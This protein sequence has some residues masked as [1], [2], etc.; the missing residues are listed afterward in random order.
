[1][2]ALLELFLTFF[3]L[4]LFT[5]GGGYAM[6]PQL[7]ETV[8]EKKK[9]LTED[10]VLNMI[11]ISESTPGPIAINMATFVGH[12]QKGFWGSLMA[13]LGV[14]LPSV[15]IIFII[16]LFF[17][18]FVS[19]KY[20]SYAFVGIKCAVAFLILKTGV[21]MFIK[22]KKKVLNVLLFSLVFLAVILF[23][24]FAIN[25]SSIIFILFGGIIGIVAYAILNR[26]T[27][28]IENEESITSKEDL[29]KED[30]IK[31]EN[32]KN[33]KINEEQIL[34]QEDKEEFAEAKEEDNKNHLNNKGVK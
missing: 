16:S 9:W 26:K 4:G 31:E 32:N 15:I 13:T 3:K 20:V 24:I 30:L 19:N 28:N 23:D 21:E 14:V 8:I 34:T 10:E 17:E 33:L 2:K 29:I 7:K 11:A 27:K 6:L 25:F 18:Q 22:M 12:K 1:M 5:F